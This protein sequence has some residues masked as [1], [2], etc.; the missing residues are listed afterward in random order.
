M[1][2]NSPVAGMAKRDEIF[3]HIASQKTAWPSMM[4]L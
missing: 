2:M 3:L 1:E 4:D